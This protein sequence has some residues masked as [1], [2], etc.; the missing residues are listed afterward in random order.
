MT[1]ERHTLA[2]GPGVQFIPI[3]RQV[4]QTVA[5]SG[6]QEGLCV[7]FVPHTTAGVTINEIADPDVMTDVAKEINQIVPFSDHYRHQEGNSSAHIKSSLF[8][9]SL[10]VPLQSGRLLLGTWQTI[11]FGEFDGPR[12]RYFFVKVMAG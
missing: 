1:C 12:T 6:V 7:I 5:K 10:T 8:G 2:T 11:Y 4:E 3:V 9:P